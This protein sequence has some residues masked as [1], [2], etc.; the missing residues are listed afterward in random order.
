MKAVGKTFKSWKCN[1]R[2]TNLA[3]CHAIFD[4]LWIGEVGSVEMTDV[5]HIVVFIFIRVAPLHLV[6]SVALNKDSN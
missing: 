6:N 2:C 4:L 1:M 3:V 5:T